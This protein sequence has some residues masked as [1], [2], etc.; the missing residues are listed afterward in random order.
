MSSWCGAQ[1]LASGLR[2]GGAGPESAVTPN[3]IGRFCSRE[4]GGHL[5]GRF[6]R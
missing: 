6:C 5:V 1:T 3:S 4:A 2:V